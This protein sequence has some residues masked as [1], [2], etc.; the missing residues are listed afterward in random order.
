VRKIIKKIRKKIRKFFKYLGNRQNITAVGTIL[1]VG[2]LSVALALV[3]ATFSRYRGILIAKEVR[4]SAYEDELKKLSGIT[5]NLEQVPDETASWQVYENQ[6]YNF[7]IKYPTDWQTPKEST[8]DSQSKYL[9]KISFDSQENSKGESRNGFDVFIYSSFKFPS[10][11]GTDSLIKKNENIDLKDCTN[12]DD[13]TLGEAGY[14]AKEINVLANDPCWEETFFYS[15][16]KNGFLY[17]IVPHSGDK[18]D[19]KNFDEKISLVKILPQF[20]DIVSTLNFT[21]KESVSQAS[22]RTVRRITTPPRPRYTAGSRCPV[23]NDHPSKSK[24]KGKHMDEDCCPDPDEW[25]N[26]RCAYGGSLG[27]MRASPKK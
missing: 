22:Q 5:T 3:A 16:N 8:F 24:T 4:Q 6:N 26:P 1:V 13:I 20:Y 21:K 15:L 2:G 18:Y 11:L 12:F 17:N 7:Y 9:L 19:I 10:Y 27:V 14:S 23:K 25:P